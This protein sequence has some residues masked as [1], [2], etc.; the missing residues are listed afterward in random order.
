M[1]QS[2]KRL[3]WLD[4]IVQPEASKSEQH[5]NSWSCSR[6]SYFQLLLTTVGCSSR[7]KLLQRKKNAA[8]TQ[9]CICCLNLFNKG[10]QTALKHSRQWLIKEKLQANA[11][12]VQIHKRRGQMLTICF[13]PSH[14]CL[15]FCS[16]LE[17]VHFCLTRAQLYGCKTNTIWHIMYICNPNPNPADKMGWD[18]FYAVSG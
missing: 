3:Q 12:K 9:I 16:N 18:T 5:F 17:K 4:Q 11:Y 6:C 7:V 10:P 14:C 8:A 15:R 13:D 1:Q 2:V